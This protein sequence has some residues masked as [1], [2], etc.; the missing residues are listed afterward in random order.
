M[1][2]IRRQFKQTKKSSMVTEDIYF[3]YGIHAWDVAAGSIILREAGGVVTDPDVKWETSGEVNAP[4]LDICQR[5]V[6]AGGNVELT[7]KF[8]A[9]LHSE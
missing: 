1:R 3:E 4:V 7:K 9:L 6:I 2:K 5:K 8:L